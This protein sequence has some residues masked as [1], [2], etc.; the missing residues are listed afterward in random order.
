MMRSEPM[1]K[2]G[3][4]TI[5]LFSQ[6]ISESCQSSTDSAQS[7]HEPAKNKSHYKLKGLSFLFLSF[8]CFSTSIWILIPS[9]VH[10]YD[11]F[12]TIHQFIVI[13]ILIVVPF[14]IL[15]VYQWVALNL[16][17]RNF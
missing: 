5:G 2:K 3:A 12:K 11:D 7:R 9:L 16:H 4:G 15:S 6:P 14:T 10:G 13:S 8:I 1:M 17:L